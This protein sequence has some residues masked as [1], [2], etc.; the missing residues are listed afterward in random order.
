[1]TAPLYAHLSNPK[2][3]SP[4]EKS[5]IRHPFRFHVDSTL[6]VCPATLR[7]LCPMNI[8]GLYFDPTFHRNIYCD[9][10]HRSD[11]RDR[12]MI[13][14]FVTKGIVFNQSRHSLSNSFYIQTSYYVFKCWE[15]R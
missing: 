10:S 11:Y 1:M 2:T 8:K 6:D 15:T 9:S 13:V 5:A 12:I 3:L 4:G 7:Y 14:L